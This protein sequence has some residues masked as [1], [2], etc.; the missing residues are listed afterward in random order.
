L[1]CSVD[2]TKG[3]QKTYL[4]YAVDPGAGTFNA[5]TGTY[6]GA[7][8]P[9]GLP[10]GSLLRIAN[11]DGADRNIHLSNTSE[12]VDRLKI[13]LARPRSTSSARPT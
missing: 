1:A 9:S 6:S 8:A 3:W 13:T 12:P 4:R 10:T 11:Y 5:A 2:H 7:V